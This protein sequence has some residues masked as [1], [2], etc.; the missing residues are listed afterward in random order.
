M[1]RL[2]FNTSELERLRK[3]VHEKQTADR[4]RQKQLR[5]QMR[6]IGFNIS[7]VSAEPEGFVVSDFDDLVSRGVI[8]ITPDSADGP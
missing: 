8:T 4:D 6:R 5:A 3:L 7:D 1:G 2:S